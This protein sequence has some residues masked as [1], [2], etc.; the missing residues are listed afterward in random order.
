MSSTIHQPISRSAKSPPELE[1][2]ERLHNCS[3]GSGPSGLLGLRRRRKRK[4]DFLS[5]KSLGEIFVKDAFISIHHISKKNP[6]I[7][8][9]STQLDKGEFLSF[10]K[11]GQSFLFCNSA[12]CSAAVSN[13]K[14]GPGNV[15]GL[16]LPSSQY[17]ESGS[18]FCPKIGQK[19]PR[20]RLH[21]ELS[22]STA[23]HPSHYQP[24][25]FSKVIS[26]FL[27]SCHDTY[28]PHTNGI[29]D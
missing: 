7:C 8:S 15:Q 10:L 14:G 20:T 21:H 4:K 25:S 23:L 26:P 3:F 12:F 6:D 19:T 18:C 11:F 1:N 17:P 16:H 24:Y 29:M 5:T 27:L 13:G 22:D 9:F 2:F 28:D